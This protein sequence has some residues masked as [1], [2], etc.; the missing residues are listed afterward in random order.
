MTRDDIIRLTRE[1]G[2][3]FIL[4]QPHQK[5]LEQLTKFA[6]L[7]A[8]GEREECAKVCDEHRQMSTNVDAF[9]WADS[10]AT[11]IRARGDDAA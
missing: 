2:M 11:V 10:C 4:G 3:T 5:V 6:E 8:K 9:E 1:S 7:V